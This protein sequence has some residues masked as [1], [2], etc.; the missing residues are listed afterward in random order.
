MNTNLAAAGGVVATILLSLFLT[1]KID[2][3]MVINGAIA[4]LVAITAEPAD[5]SGGQAIIIGAAGGALVYYSIL[6]FDKVLKLDDPVGAISAHGIVGI[7]GVMVVP[8]TDGDATFLWQ[9]YGVVAIAG[10]TFFTSLVA[11][12]VINK[13]FTI[14][15]SDE[16]QDLGLD[17]TE[18]G[19]E[20]YPEFK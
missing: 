14:R 12:L 13:V 10:F 16:E 3:T 8:F 11:I 15:A 19:I 1:K 7:L 2:V 20:A 17:V 18:I 6:F 5:P 4:G 9:F